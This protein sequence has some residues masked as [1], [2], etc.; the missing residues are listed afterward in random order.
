MVA[1]FLGMVLRTKLGLEVCGRATDA[2][3]ALRLAREERPDLVIVDITLAEGHGLELLKDLACLPDPPKALVVSGHD[4]IQYAERAL[5]AGAMG[6]VRKT[7][8]IAVLLDAV[9]RVLAGKMHVSP[10]LA[11]QLVRRRRS[12]SSGGGAVV[13]LTD[14]ELEVLEGL[15]HGRTSK[16]IAASLGIDAGTVETYRTRLREK[17]GLDSSD[18]LRL[19]AFQW[20]HLGVR[21]DRPGIDPSPSVAPGPV[22]APRGDAGRTPSARD[23]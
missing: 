21:P 17:L 18:A 14:R 9:R 16:D 2:R 12:P 22:K 3:G 23:R 15:G 1:E 7:H 4:E 13:E 10:D 8:D 20:V 11:S 6:Y 5:A 19:Y